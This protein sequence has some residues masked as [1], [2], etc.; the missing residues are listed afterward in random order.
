MYRKIFIFCLLSL[1]YLGASRI[2]FAV[3]L[4]ELKVYSYLNEPLSAEI[5]LNGVEEIDTN[6]ILVELASS[7]DFM[8]TGI[9]RPFFLSKLK[10]EVVRKNDTTV[11]YVSTNKSV[12]EP[13]LDFLIQTVWPEGKIV[14]SYTAL[15]D[16]TPD[17]LTNRDIPISKQ[18]SI[19]SGV[20]KKGFSD[21][22]FATSLE[23]P[24]EN[25]LSTEQ[26]QQINT[27][28]DAI[29]NE[30]IAAAPLTTSEMNPD[31]PTAANIQ[32][33]SNYQSG[34]LD[35][36][37]SS[38]QVFSQQPKRVPVDYEKLLDLKPNNTPLHKDMVPLAESLAMTQINNELESYRNRNNEHVNK[39]S[40][41]TTT[42]QPEV[43]NSSLEVVKKYGN[44]LLWAC[45]LVSTTVFLLYK[46]MQQNSTST[47][48]IEF[49]GQFNDK[50]PTSEPIPELRVNSK[51]NVNAAFE[52]IN[53][54]DIQTES[55]QTIHPPP[56]TLFSRNEELE[57]KI[58]LAKQYLEAGDRNSARDI[59]Q[60]F[61]TATIKEPRYREQIDSLLK[62][63]V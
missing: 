41:V 8:R 5:I 30:A 33:D 4:G 39:S 34:V 42:V 45:F 53:L 62:C 20:N 6:N 51:T 27:I 35:K 52:Q 25:E 14:K 28:A 58:E 2:A 12:K 32:Q 22:I 47:E 3:S 18:K 13:Y 46:M 1:L 31:E 49:T 9:P 54:Q 19:P 23:D 37:A 38:L 29:A 59:L 57:L 11:I 43:Y 50:P 48:S 56:H 60:D 15:L 10:F 17:N 21:A 61:N 55:T 26:K 40:T 16:P 44:D 36:V 24:M 63:L 7:K